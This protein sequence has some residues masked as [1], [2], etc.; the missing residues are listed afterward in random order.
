MKHIEGY[1]IAQ[2]EIQ[3]SSANKFCSTKFIKDHKSK[4]E[5]FYLSYKRLASL[6][7]EIPYIF[8]KKYEALLIYINV[9]G[10]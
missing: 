7:S 3:L 9:Y 10:N 4:S 6:S 1:S 5:L 2:L 8:S